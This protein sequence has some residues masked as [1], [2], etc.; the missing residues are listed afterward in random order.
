MDVS[1]LGTEYASDLSD[2][3]ACTRYGELR[4]ALGDQAA[5]CML[6]ELCDERDTADPV[7]ASIFDHD[8]SIGLEVDDAEDHWLRDAAAGTWTRVI[9]VPRR[10]TFHPSEGEGGP[11]LGSLSGTRSTIPM[12]VEAVRD[13]WKAAQLDEDLLGD[14]LWTGRCIFRVHEEHILCLCAAHHTENGIG[15]CVV[16]NH[17]SPLVPLALALNPRRSV[18]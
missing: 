6:T 4:Q 11:N 17:P 3:T 5:L 8:S 18:P 10:K 14:K 13:N 2:A 7:G 1:F 12:H 9:K 15:L 16:C